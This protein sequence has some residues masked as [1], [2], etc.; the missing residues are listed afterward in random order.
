[1]VLIKRSWIQ[2]IWGNI[3]IDMVD[4]FALY[5]D[6]CISFGNNSCNCLMIIMD[7]LR[8]ERKIIE[9]RERKNNGS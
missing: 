7:D 6:G 4:H 3:S 8:E 2:R 5:K 1:M 9:L